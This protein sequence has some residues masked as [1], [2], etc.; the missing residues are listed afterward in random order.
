MPC[1]YH[2]PVFIPVLSMVVGAALLFVGVMVVT[3][4]GPSWLSVLGAVLLGL[5]LIVA[6]IR[7]S[8]A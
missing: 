3:V 4:P 6:V 2:A 7:R 5:G 8:K 1:I